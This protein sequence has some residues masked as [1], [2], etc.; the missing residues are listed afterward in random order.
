LNLTSYD[1]RFETNADFSTEANR[2]EFIKHVVTFIVH[3]V[4]VGT[5]DPTEIK[6]A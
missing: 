1:P 5:Q 3:V 2:V 6:H 4:D